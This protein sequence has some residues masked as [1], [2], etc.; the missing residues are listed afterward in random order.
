M[1]SVTIATLICLHDH[2]LAERNPGKKKM[3]ALKFTENW[4]SIRGLPPPKNF[5]VS[6]TLR[7]P[8]WEV[9]TWLCTRRTRCKKEF[10]NTAQ[11]SVRTRTNERQAYL[12]ALENSS[13][14]TA[15]L[16]G[17]SGWS[18]GAICLRL[19]TGTPTLEEKTLQR[20][21]AA[22]NSDAFM[23]KIIARLC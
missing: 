23:I 21:A 11:P 16:S 6:L 19:T 8:V 4:S 5:I 17:H 14:A 10:T 2:N 15:R 20:T 3:Y 7:K 18:S 13:R 9:C 12:F 22:K 1:L